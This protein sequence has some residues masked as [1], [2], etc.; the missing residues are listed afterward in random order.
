MA[1]SKVTEKDV[2]MFL[3]DKPELNPLLRGARW[4][5]EEIDHAI[6][7][8]VS[9]YNETPPHVDT[10]TAENFPYQYTL[11]LGVAGY[12]LKSAAINEASNELSYQVDGV[13]VNDKDKAEIFLKLGTQYWTEF[14]TAIQNTKVSKNVSA[15]FGSATSEHR[16]FAR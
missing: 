9:Y 11:L 16:T 7:M 15:A 1:T 6:V 5:P 8:V 10:Y 2:R 3:M 14:Q 4:S 13:A 12:L